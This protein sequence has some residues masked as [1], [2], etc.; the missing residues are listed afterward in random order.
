MSRHRKAPVRR[1]IIKPIPVAKS[2]RRSASRRFVA[3]R[4]SEGFK[5]LVLDNLTE[6]GDVIP[7]S[8]F[9]GVGLYCHDLFFGLI[10][11]D[12]MYL[13]VDAANRSD[14]ERAGMQPFKPYR[15]R[16]G[17]MQYYAVP[18]EVVECAPELVEWSR[19]AVAVAERARKA[20]AGL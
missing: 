9:G 16:A 6:L 12:V 13:K 15:D 18:L 7:R 10:A 11:A 19:R 2:R 5:A 8:M 17:T 20:S 4:V 14:F 3:M 1:G